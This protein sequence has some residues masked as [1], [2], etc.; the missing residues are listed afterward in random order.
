MM[1]RYRRQ[2]EKTGK[3]DINSQWAKTRLPQVTQYLEEIR[4]EELDI[5]AIAWFDEK[6]KQCKIGCDSKTETILCKDYEDRMATAATGGAWG[7][8]YP[9]KV[10]K[11]PKEA[12]ACFG[13]AVVR[14]D[15]QLPP[16]A[17]HDPTT[18]IVRIGH[19]NDP[20]EYTERLVVG[21]KRYNQELEKEDQRIVK[22]F[23]AW[24]NHD[25]YESRYPGFGDT[26]LRKKVNNDFCCITDIMDHCVAFGNSVYHGTYAEHNWRIFVG[27]TAQGETGEGSL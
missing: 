15:A 16:G 23:G 2:T 22:Q 10:V 5:D 24:K 1:K 8:R 17:V 12:R 26:E 3:T 19:K 18:P 11:F 20:F 4:T 27:L 6:H 7:K 13:A 9:S 25:S 21:L 14:M